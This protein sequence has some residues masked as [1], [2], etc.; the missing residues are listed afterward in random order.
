MSRTPADLV[1][2]GSKTMSYDFSRYRSYMEQNGTDAVVASS[3][4]ATARILGRYFKDNM[5]MAAGTREFSY[6]AGCNRKGEPLASTEWHFE[7]NIRAVAGRLKEKGLDR[8]V[9]G[10]EMLDLPAMG[11]EMFRT[12]LPAATFMDATWVIRS[13]GLWVHEF[14][15]VGSASLGRYQDYIFESGQVLSVEAI[16]EQSFVLTDDGMQRI[17]KMPMKIY[18]S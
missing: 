14:P 8:G 18:V 12:E 7:Q 16:A 15:Q 11:L 17:G 4:E 10:V 2:Q 13:C 9:I 5:W 3:Y 1:S 6:L